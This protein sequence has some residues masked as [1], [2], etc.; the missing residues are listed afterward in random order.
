VSANPLVEI[1]QVLQPAR[2]AV[3]T[4]QRMLVELLKEYSIRK[5]KRDL[6]TYHKYISR[7]RLFDKLATKL[8]QWIGRRLINLRLKR[9]KCIRRHCP[10]GFILLQAIHRGRL[11]RNKP[12][13]VAEIHFKH[14]SHLSNRMKIAFEEQIRSFETFQVSTAFIKKTKQCRVRYSDSDHLRDN[15]KLE[16]YTFLEANLLCRE[17]IGKQFLIFHSKRVESHAQACKTVLTDIAD[18]KTTLE[19]IEYIRGKIDSRISFIMAN[20][21]NKLYDMF[22]EPV[23]K[24][25]IQKNSEELFKKASDIEVGWLRNCVNNELLPLKYTAKTIV[26][27]FAYF[28][29]QRLEAELRTHE[30]LQQISSRV[31]QL[32]RQETVYRK[33]LLSV[34]IERIQCSTK[35]AQKNT[36]IR[37]L[38]QAK[39]IR[40]CITNIYEET[41]KEEMRFLKTCEI[42]PQKVSA[43]DVSEKKHI[44]KTVHRVKKEVKY[45]AWIVEL[46]SEWIKPKGLKESQDQILQRQNSVANKNEQ[47]AHLEN[48]KAEQEK[49]R[50]NELEMMLELEKTTGKRGLKP[51]EEL[52]V[53]AA[54]G[55][56][57]QDLK[58]KLL[59]SVM[60]TSK[61]LERKKIL[62]SILNKQGEGVGVTAGI[63]ELRF[64]VG[65]DEES[66]MA[67]Q[68]LEERK[69]GVPEFQ[70]IRRDLCCIFK[71]PGPVFLWVKKD[72]NPLL[73][74]KTLNLTTLAES[75]NTIRH[76][77]FPP[78]FGLQFGFLGLAK[79]SIVDIRFSFTLEEQET[80][81]RKH[82]EQII[83]EVSMVK[84]TQIV[85]DKCYM[86]ILRLDNFSKRR[87]LD[88]EMLAGR[89]AE[90]QNI[91]KENPVNKRIRQLLE[92]TQLDIKEQLYN[93]KNIE[94]DILQEALDLVAMDSQDLKKL[95]VGFAC[96]DGDQSG[97]ISLQELFFY[98]GVRLE[99][100]GQSIFSF[101]DDSGDSK[102]Q[103]AEFVMSLVTFCMFGK[104]EMAQLVFNFG[105]KSR[106]GRLSKSQ[107]KDMLQH[108]HNIDPDEHPDLVKI[109]KYVEA[110]YLDFITFED[111][112]DIS[113]R[114]VRVMRPVIDIQFAMMNRFLG[115]KWWLRK[116]TLFEAC[117]KEVIQNQYRDEKKLMKAKYYQ[118]TNQLPPLQ[119]AQQLIAKKMNQLKKTSEVVVGKYLPP[120]QNNNS[121]SSDDDESS[122]EEVD[123][124]KVI[125]NTKKSY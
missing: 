2:D 40:G 82:Y 7:A 24:L 33:E 61:K 110:T 58:S 32:H 5:E 15:C 31:D 22:D 76:E 81:R 88:L 97:E 75:T 16:Y 71:L 79:D 121:E 107:F 12:N 3:D 1:A 52:F 105:D 68:S 30:K 4:K 77:K 69:R 112:M 109:L 101:L 120:L 91:L 25:L 37:L 93:N 21:G 47:L 50:H 19:K 90:Y 123:L 62:K 13:I 29:V 66:E 55:K 118:T 67:V 125:H 36:A 45:L 18:L 26:A 72:A 60:N 92:E 78:K 23:L 9:L 86:W 85:R 14:I 27:R 46:S 51:M 38:E 96:C 124:R 99:P 48:L 41:Q 80:L 6:E 104:K 57:K 44:L 113:S 100:V 43:P 98:I 65:E 59:N 84:T 111:F 95:T 49:R 34:E 35:K 70:C 117:R 102:L 53:Q 10:F 94:K 63:S 119:L 39:R 17:S 56:K 89:E 73:Q 115:E 64:T 106:L 74:I 103:F 116:K 42:Q 122:C 54:N 83:P 28:E 114:H 87:V 11:L 8:Q 108:V 20:H